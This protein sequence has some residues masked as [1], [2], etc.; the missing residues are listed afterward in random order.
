MSINNRDKRFDTRVE[1][2]ALYAQA[3]FKKTD[4]SVF[5]IDAKI[6][7]VGRCGIRLKFNRSKAKAIDLG[8]ELILET[9]MPESNTPISIRANIVHELSDAEFGAFY[10]DVQ[11]QGPIEQLITECRKIAS[12][13]HTLHLVS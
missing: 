4:H 8:D 3:T 10:M 13:N 9:N 2:E 6:L 12:K 1:T 7:D 5:I 11:P